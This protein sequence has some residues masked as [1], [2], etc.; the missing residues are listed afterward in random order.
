MRLSIQIE[1]DKTLDLD[2]SKNSVLVGRS[3]KSDL[4]INHDSISRNHCRITCEKGIFY[5]T[6]LGSSNGTFIDGGRL[7]PNVINSFISSQQLTIGSLECEVSES[8]TPL[9]GQPKII[10]TKV[11]SSGG[12]TET[13]RVSR[14]DL[15]RPV[16]NPEQRKINNAARSAAGKLKQRKKN[17]LKFLKKVFI[18]AFVV[19]A[20]IAAWKLAPH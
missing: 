3:P 7:D 15:N 18:I 13:V 2:T 17:R 9:A 4:I 11:A 14:I 10:S 19:L 1:F 6:D 16:L 20:L 12:Y 8:F 5:I